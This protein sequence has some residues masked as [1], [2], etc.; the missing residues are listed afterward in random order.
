ML[1]NSSPGDSGAVYMHRVTYELG[2]RFRT[3]SS[4]GLLTGYLARGPSDAGVML[5]VLIDR[6]T[7]GEYIRQYEKARSI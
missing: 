2:K 1:G 7:G 5:F 4:P 6:R 3:P